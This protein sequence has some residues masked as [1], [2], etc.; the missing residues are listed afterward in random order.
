MSAAAAVLAESTG[1]DWASVQTGPCIV[2]QARIRGD[3]S[4]AIDAFGDDTWNLAPMGIDGVQ[5]Q[6]IWWKPANRG[7]RTQSRPFPAHFIDAFKR[8]TWLIINYQTP[9]SILGTS[10]ANSWRSPGS[11]I[12]RI[13][14]W[15][16]FA[17]FLGCHQV[18]RLSDVS[19]DLLDM[20][21]NE[22]IS[23]D[24]RSSMSKK[25][26][27]LSYV[28][29]VAG[30]AKWLPAS[31]ALT[32]PSW[33]GQPLNLESRGGENR[34][35][36]IDPDTF[37]PLMWWSTQIMACAPDVIAAITAHTGMRAILASKVSP[38]SEQQRMDQVAHIVASRG[39]VLPGKEKD[40]GVLPAGQYLAA[41]HGGVHA[42]D[43]GLWVRKYGGSFTVDPAI[44]QPL[45][46]PVIGTIEGK[47]W[48]PCLDWR[49]VVALHRIVMGAAAVLIAACSGMRGS[50]CLNLPLQCLRTIRRPDGADSYR[51]DGRTRKG[52]RDDDDQHSLEGTEWIWAT[53][54]PGAAAIETLQS[55]AEVTGSPRLFLNPNDQGGQG[56]GNIVRTQTASYW[57]AQLMD[58]ANE[59]SIALDLPGHDIPADPGGH[60]QLDRFRRTVAWHIVNQPQGLIAAGVQFGQLHAS[61]T[62]GYS[63]YKNS[64]IA[65]TM[66]QERSQALYSTL[67]AH[68]QAAMTGERASGPAAG[69]VSK[70]LASFATKFA[71]P[72]FPGTFVR[73]GRREQRALETDPDIQLHQ[74]PGKFC[75]CMFRTETA[76]CEPRDG[77]PD[78]AECKDGCANR[79]YTDT[80]VA[81]TRQFIDIIRKESVDASAPMRRRY[82]ATI[83]RAL[84]RIAEHERMAS[85]LRVSADVQGNA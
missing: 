19:T 7:L 23:D 78:R 12:G 83:D 58:F 31:D 46:I 85:P 18:A 49:D 34:K 26:L 63:G 52:K 22:L 47:Q 43:F 66:N 60:I 51:I 21:A 64:G 10:N 56:G 13:N 1:L 65:A 30:Y 57:I 73:L 39:G 68:H 77:Q 27:D 32:T 71:D 14:T 67:A 6:N 81:Q 8:L 70:A 4:S 9:T 75:L 33:V 48:L 59:R 40:G 35:E 15:R 25:A 5:R 55:L 72:E 42:K 3:Q 24:S 44:L 82:E 69:R 62:E 38:G 29:E 36:I 45:P 74:V 50:E 37:A 28:A 76:A 80:T 17:H 79:A 84:D 20:F 16:E 53:I 41:F 2:T 11:I 54:K 61:T